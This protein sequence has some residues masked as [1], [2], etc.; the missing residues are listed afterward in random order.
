MTT[1]VLA[2]D[3]PLFRDG[4]RALLTSVDDAEFAGE[5]SRADRSRRSRSSLRASRRC[6]SSDP[7]Q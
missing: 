3:H 6:W 1:L 4:L 7:V 2:D 5:A